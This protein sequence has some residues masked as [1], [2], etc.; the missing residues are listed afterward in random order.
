MI[1]WSEIQRVSDK[2]EEASSALIPA[3]FSS[4][5]DNDFSTASIQISSSNRVYS[6]D[7]TLILSRENESE[8]WG[9][10]VQSSAAGAQVHEL[11]L[12]FFTSNDFTCELLFWGQDWKTTCLVFNSKQ[13]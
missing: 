4:S 13:N 12:S 11:S 3:E 7:A 8:K 6:T 2:E 10:R 9:L 1:K 5:L